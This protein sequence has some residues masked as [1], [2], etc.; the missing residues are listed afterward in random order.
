M[1]K[2]FLVKDEGTQAFEQRKRE[3]VLLS[4]HSSNEASGESGLN[5]VRLTH[6]SLPE[7][8]FEDI[9]ISRKAFGHQMATPF[10]V[11][12]MTAGH[13]DSVDLNIRLARAS[14]QHGW[15]MGVG[16]QRRQLTDEKAKSEWRRLKDEVPEVRL[17]GNIGLSQLITVNPESIQKLVSSLEAVAMIVHLNPLQ[18]CLQMEGTPYFANGIKAIERLIR[19]LDVPVVLKETGCGISQHTFQR[20]SELKLGAVDVS[21]FGGT[22]WGRI[23]GER[24]R[25]LR[26]SQRESKKPTD[27]QTQ[28]LIETANVFSSWG[29]STVDSL[30]EGLKVQPSFELW[31]SGGVRTG[32]DA[33]KLLA[34]GAEA[35]GYAKP[36]LEAALVGEAELDMK[37]STF[38]YQLKVAM[39]CVGCRDLSSLKEMRPWTLQS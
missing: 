39:L 28:I 33:A 5:R 19:R 36:I 22:H 35:V 12:S 17:M 25:L 15:L 18:E 14:A 10:L 20:I 37:M 31:A 38:E 23:E 11:S 32:L 29:L 24:A 21:G 34:M 26:E 27:M 3:H 7:I 1:A 9:N 16:S 8:N 13:Q 6:N 30:I 2:G 4:L